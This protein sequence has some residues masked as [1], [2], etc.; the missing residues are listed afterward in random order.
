MVLGACKNMLKFGVLGYSTKNSV[1]FLEDCMCL[2]TKYNLYIHQG[3]GST[4]KGAC[5]I[6][7]WGSHDRRR[8]PAA[9][10]AM[11]STQMHIYK[12][13]QNKCKQ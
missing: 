3:D 13:G 5:A 2:I 12:H 10:C 8:E 4:G 9:G 6:L 11:T 1:S 7:G